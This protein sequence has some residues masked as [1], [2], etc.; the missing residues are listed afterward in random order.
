MNL[1]LLINIGVLV[2]TLISPFVSL[3]AVSFI[4][5]GNYKIHMVIQKRLFLACIISLLVL[6]GLIRFSGGSGS[7]VSNSNYVNT[8]FFKSILSA[9]IIGA[10]LT[11]VVWGVLVFTSNRKYKHSDLP[12]SFSKL[13]KNLGYITITGLFYTAVTALMVFL[14][15]F[16]L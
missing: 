9:H 2:L 13:H 3:Y 10:V 14:L 7:L 8:S 4:K 1:V 6:E 12:G 5:K 11:Y 15:T 16:V